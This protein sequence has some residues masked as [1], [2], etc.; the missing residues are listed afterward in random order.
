M[1]LSSQVKPVSYLK[2]HAAEIVRNL[3]P[4]SSNPLTI[5]N[6]VFSCNGKRPMPRHSLPLPQTARF[7]KSSASLKCLTSYFQVLGCSCHAWH[8]CCCM[9]MPNGEPRKRG[10]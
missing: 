10:R 6:L 5:Y 8:R 1:Q 2:A 7:L 3:E 9:R 4:E